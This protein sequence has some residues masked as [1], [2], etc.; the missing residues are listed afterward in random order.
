MS[1]RRIATFTGWLWII[2]SGG[3]STGSTGK[4][5]RSARWQWQEVAVT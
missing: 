1:Y 5:G 4:L 2:T 3:R